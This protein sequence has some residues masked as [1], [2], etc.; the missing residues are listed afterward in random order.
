VCGVVA[1]EGS[2]HPPINLFYCHYHNCIRSELDGLSKSVL[3]LEYSKDED[4]AEYLT[5]LKSKVS[6]LE[7][8]YNIHSSVEDEVCKTLEAFCLSSLHFAR[9]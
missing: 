9:V 1:P 6:F 2:S 3:A 5:K 8:V 4:L 7:R